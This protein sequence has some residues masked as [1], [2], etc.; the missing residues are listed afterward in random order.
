MTLV[1]FT[2]KNMPKSSAEFIRVLQKARKGRSLLDD[3]F[4]LSQELVRL[5]IKHNMRSDTFYK[6]FQ[7]GK[8][9]DSMEFIRW[10]NKYEFYREV[11]GDLEHI[12]ELLDKYALPVMA[13]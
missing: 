6:K 3:Y 4:D 9:N 12:F 5:E 13:V 11:K 7:K 2:K 8:L 1:K 10:A